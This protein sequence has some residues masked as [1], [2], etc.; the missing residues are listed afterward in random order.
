MK[1]GAPA[2][3]TVLGQTNAARGWHENKRDGGAVLSVPSGDVVVARLAMPHSPRW[4]NG[5]L[6]LL[7]SGTGS[8]G[9]IDIE[10]G[11]YEPIVHLPGFTRG[12]DFIGR[13][14]FVGLS[15][16]RESATFSGLPVTEREDRSS[17]VW[18]VDTIRGEVVAFLR[19]D[20]NVQ[21]IFAVQLLVNCKNPELVID[22]NPLMANAF[23]LPD[24]QL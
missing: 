16:V 21:E 3:V 13:Y 24:K 5:K 19:F 23:V 17:G 8:L 9:T 1:D 2:F 20:G 10:R 15:Q 4:H 22:D 12:L 14:A 6:W 18:V 11:L 7:E